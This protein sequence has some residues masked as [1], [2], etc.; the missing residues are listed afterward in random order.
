MDSAMTR[1]EHERLYALISNPPPGSEIAAAKEFGIDL[2]LTLRSLTMTPTERSRAMEDALRLIEAI[3]SAA[4][5]AGK[6]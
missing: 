1:K 5:R 6:V 2:S 3:E 4:R